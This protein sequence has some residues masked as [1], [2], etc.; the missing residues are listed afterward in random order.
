METNLRYKK[1]P[2]I[3]E[4]CRLEYQDNQGPRVLLLFDKYYLKNSFQCI[5]WSARLNRQFL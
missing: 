3:M 4:V 2:K 1:N 5:N